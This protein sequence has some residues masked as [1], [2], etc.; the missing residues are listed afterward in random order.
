MVK[1]DYYENNWTLRAHELSAKE[2]LNSNET[3]SLNAMVTSPDVENN[4]IGQELIRLKIVDA[5]TKGLNEG[6]TKALIEVVNF[7]RSDDHDA[8]CIKGYAGTG[9]T[10]L[11]RRVIEYITTAYPNRKIAITAP[12][13]KA[14]HVL[15][16]NSPF[17]NNIPIFEAYGKPTT[18]L[19]YSTIHKLLG[20]KEQISANGAQN[21]VTGED[22]DIT[23][24]SYLI[25]DEVSMLNDDLFEKLMKFKHKVKFIFMGD[26]AQIPPIG[27][28][29][30]IPF[31]EN[32]P[33]DLKKVV[34]SEIMRQKKGNPLVA[35]S[36]GLRKN[37]TAVNPIDV[38][39]ALT[40]DGEGLIAING[41]IP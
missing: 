4:H 16:K 32:C 30:C 40:L 17:G 12:T 10:H 13:N 19:V 38:K 20:L 27:K 33:Y 7:F 39:T 31:T 28:E 41:N 25:V 22:V 18:K 14:V 23:K 29:H 3:E 6:Q 34:L 24:Y 5:L 35:A 1:E 8:F 21:F 15:H 9:K 37:L 26:P 36:M 11:V 2:Q